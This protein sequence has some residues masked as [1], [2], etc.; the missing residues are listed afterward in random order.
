MTQEP[1]QLDERQEAQYTDGFVVALAGL[2]KRVDALEKE[3]AELKGQVSAQP[4]AVIRA[5]IEMLR[6]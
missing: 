3:L 2:F 4:E 5:I 6:R 1:K